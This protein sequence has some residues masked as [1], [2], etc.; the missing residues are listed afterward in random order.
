MT[1]KITKDEIKNL[2]QK[3]IELIFYIRNKFRWGEIIIE[4]RDGQPFRM[5]K[6]TEYQTLD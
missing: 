4:T 2:T 5:R 1:K 6:V 3:E